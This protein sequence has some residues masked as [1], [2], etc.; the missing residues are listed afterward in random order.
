MTTSLQDFGENQMNT[1][2]A[3]ECALYV[4]KHCP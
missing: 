4:L 3:K 2:M 1:L